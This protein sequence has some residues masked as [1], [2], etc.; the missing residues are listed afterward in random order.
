MAGF[1]DMTIDPITGKAKVKS[2]TA[3]GTP[4][5]T[6]LPYIDQKN[7]DALLT[8][9][10]PASIP[11]TQQGVAQ[12]NTNVMAQAQNQ[13][14]AQPDTGIAN[15]TNEMVKQ[16]QANPSFGYQ[17]EQYKTNALSNYDYNQANAVKTFKEQNADLGG[18]GEINANLM[19]TILAG[20]TD[21]SNLENQ[22]NM[23]NVEQA[24]KDWAAAIAA[25]N[26]QT[27]QNANLTQQGINNLL[28]VRQGFEGERSQESAQKFQAEQQASAQQFQGAE[29]E[30]AR[31]EAAR[32]FN[33]EEDFKKWATQ[34]GWDQDSINRAWQSQENQASRVSTEKIAQWNIDTEKWKT[35]EATKLTQQGWTE[36]AARQKTQIDAEALQGDLNR[37]LQKLISD[38][39]L[40]V[41]ESKIALQATQFSDELSFKRWATQSG[42]DDNTA[43]RAWQAG[44]NAIKIASDEKLARDALNTETYN[45]ELDRAMT[46]EIESGRIAQEDKALVQQAT[47]AKD[48]LTWQKQ[49]TLMGIDANKATQI[50]QATENAKDRAQTLA[51]SNNQLNLE[52]QKLTSSIDQF[53]KQYGLESSKYIAGIEQWQSE[54][55]QKTKEWEAASGLQKTQL[56]QELQIANSQM[57]NQITL[58]TIDNEARLKGINLT[59]TLDNLQNM[60]P[61]TAAATLVQVM[62]QSG[63]DTTGVMA[64]L[65]NYKDTPLPVIMGQEDSPSLTINQDGSIA[66]PDG[67]YSLA[68]G[69]TV[70]FQD[71]FKAANGT[72]VPSGSYT[73]M[74]DANSM[75]LTGTD[76][77]GNSVSYKIAEKPQMPNQWKWLGG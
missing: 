49:A 69:Q 57:A 55:A 34:G 37:T 20:N 35:N 31:N 29:N 77:A 61:T 75:S 45:K 11:A 46:K 15:K 2:I 4:T 27:T 9:V 17:G 58:A 3:P 36:E 47:L 7:P 41:E 62:Q 28:N 6:T 64:S 52:T 65:K 59:A 50:W 67:S 22:L 33:T 56:A 24:K 60:D 25:G 16:M 26:T 66:T 44:Q 8:T 13:A 30:K 43:N 74:V 38:K 53:D 18:H 73:V 14:L 76:K 42:I 12:G 19:K 48:Q 10:Q 21:R 40:S 68:A 63:L 5:S 51:I 23:Q 1:N 32:Q 54:F 71:N 70:K 39:T 72:T